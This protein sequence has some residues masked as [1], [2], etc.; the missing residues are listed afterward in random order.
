MG[1]V[2]SD[3][4]ALVVLSEKKYSRLQYRCPV[5]YGRHTDSRAAVGLFVYACVHWVLISIF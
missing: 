5:I 3:E 1:T 2:Y 4:I